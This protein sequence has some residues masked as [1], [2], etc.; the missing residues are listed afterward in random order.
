MSHAAPMPLKPARPACL[1]SGFTLIELMVVIGIIALLVAISV[2]AMG[3]LLSANEY[4][5]VKNTLS[6][7]VTTAQSM[8]EALGTPVAIRIEQSFTPHRFSFNTQY[9]DG[10]RDFQKPADVVSFLPHQQ[11]R[12]VRFSS[13]PPQNNTGIATTDEKYQPAFEDI[14]EAR[15]TQLPKSAWVAP[16][17]CIDRDPNN[18]ANPWWKL[19]INSLKYAP[20]KIEDVQA[21]VPTPG[22]N[23]NTLPINRMDCFYIAFDRQGS[24]H[25]FTTSPTAWQTHYW[26]R[27]RSQPIEDVNAASGIT[28]PPAVFPLVDHP[29]SSTRGLL[30]YNRSQFLELPNTDNGVADETNPATRRGLLMKAKPLYVNRSLGEL[31]E[32]RQ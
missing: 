12:L 29:D 1:R 27:D 26:F 3:P 19:D 21:K 18:L 16:I 13:Q 2:P 15:V 6:G 8:A 32:G 10:M 31:V 25:Q 9:Y 7:M 4:A 11:A 30:V 5:Q 17:E 24:L 23:P 22:D 20:K 14:P 28:N